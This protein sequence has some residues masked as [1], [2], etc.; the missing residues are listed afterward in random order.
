MGRRLS[1]AGRAALVLALSLA[2]MA[3]V[4]ATAPDD[5]ALAAPGAADRHRQLVAALSALRQK[6]RDV[7][8]ALRRVAT[9]SS[10]AEAKAAA[11]AVL[12]T[13]VGPAGRHFGDADHDGE[14]ARVDP[15]GILPGEGDLLDRGYALAASDASSALADAPGADKRVA[16]MAGQVRSEIEQAVLGSTRAW[17]DPWRRYDEIDGAVDGYRPNHNTIG[18]IDGHMLRAVAWAL[19]VLRSQTLAEAKEFAGHGQI[20]TA[21]SLEAVERAYGAVTAR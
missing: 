10:L 19:L 16:A 6:L 12:N 21:L 17:E 9:A 14:M 20:H 2:G 8:A 13:S 7:D 5:V 18:L 11:E 15:M 4:A 1:G 3:S